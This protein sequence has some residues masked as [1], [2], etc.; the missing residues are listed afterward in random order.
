MLGGPQSPEGPMVLPRHRPTSSPD[1]PKN[2]VTLLQSNLEL[3]CI[4]RTDRR[5]PCTHTVSSNE[6]TSSKSEGHTLLTNSID[7]QRMIA[8]Y[9]VR[10]SDEYSLCQLEGH[11]S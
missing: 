2:I 11:T 1:H 6:C 7:D 3:S 4:H 5:M 8:A 9:T 10:S